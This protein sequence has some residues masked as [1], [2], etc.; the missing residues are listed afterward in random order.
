MSRVGIKP[1][2]SA[3]AGLIAVG[4]SLVLARVHPFGDAG[5]YAAKSADTPI[6]SNARVPQEVRA[7]LV[8]A[9]PQ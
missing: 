5:L 7:I 2:R 3:L 1:I 9:H 8:D 6:L 4:A